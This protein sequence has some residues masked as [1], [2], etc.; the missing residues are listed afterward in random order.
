MSKN[1][2]NPSV[3]S[4]SVS[5]AIYPSKKQITKMYMY[6]SSQKLFFVYL[7]TLLLL[8]FV[9]FPLTSLCVCIFCIYEKLVMLNSYVSV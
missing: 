7:N 8:F 1:A 2:L 3:G 4:L 6:P 5:G 9:V